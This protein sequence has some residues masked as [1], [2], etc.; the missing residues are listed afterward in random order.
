MNLMDSFFI[1]DF[2]PVYWGCVSL[3]ILFLFLLIL[4]E[5]SSTGNHSVCVC[6]KVTKRLIRN[7]YW[8]FK[9]WWWWCDCYFFFILTC[10][11]IKFIIGKFSYHYT[12]D[13]SF[14]NS[15]TLLCWR[16]FKIFVDI[17]S[18][19]SGGFREIGSCTGEMQRVTC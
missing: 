1:V 15:H 19:I 17:N 7:I 2:Q 9:W 13:W 11:F 14:A 16:Y 6:P 8:K 4:S 5:L 18:W 12:L 3:L 10:N